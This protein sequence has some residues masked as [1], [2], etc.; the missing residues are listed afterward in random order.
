MKTETVERGKTTYLERN[1]GNM[2]PVAFVSL[3]KIDKTC[4][5]KLSY[6]EKSFFSAD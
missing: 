3:L 5:K 1:T 6:E 4:I 2:G